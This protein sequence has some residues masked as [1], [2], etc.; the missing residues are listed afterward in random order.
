LGDAGRITDEERIEQSTTPELPGGKHK[1]NECDLSD[2]HAPAIS[3]LTA[4]LR[5]R[6]IDF[7]FCGVGVHA[8]ASLF[9][10]R[11]WHSSSSQIV[12]YSARNA[13]LSCMRKTSRGRDIATLSTLTIR[14]G[15]ALIRTTRSPSPIASCRS[16]VM[17]TIVTPVRLQI[18]S[19]WSCRTTRVCASSGPNGSSIRLT[20]GA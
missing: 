4:A 19:S 18:S 6:I 11:T 1:D 16:W 15:L 2:G 9:L 5:L 12:S 8:G 17:K 10:F 14:P 7:L 20:L 13:P 3:L